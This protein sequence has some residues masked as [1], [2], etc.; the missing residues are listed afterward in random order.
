[1]RPG[2]TGLELGFGAEGAQP[3]EQ[4]R[5][6][7]AEIDEA[8]TSQRQIEISLE[9][10]ELVDQL[11]REGPGVL[12]FAFG[13]GESAVRLEIAVGRIGHAHLGFK[14]SSGQTKAF[15]SR[16]KGCVEVGSDVKRKGHPM[17]EELRLALSKKDFCRFYAPLQGW[18]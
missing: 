15:G 3:L 10:S 13:E 6:F 17:I 18:V 4:G 7:Q 9:G 1:V 8:R 11:L 16:A 2:G 12:L 5:R 14:A